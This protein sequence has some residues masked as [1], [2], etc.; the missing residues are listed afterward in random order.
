VLH[1]SGFK[2]SDYVAIIIG[3]VSQNYPGDGPPKL[4]V[5]EGC[6]V[7]MADVRGSAG[8]TVVVPVSVEGAEGVFSADMEVRFD[9]QLLTVVDVDTTAWTTGFMSAYHS[10]DGVIRIAMAGDKK[11]QGAGDIARIT[12]RVNPGLQEGLECPLEL[13]VSLNEGIVPVTISTGMFTSGRLVPET[14]ELAQ[15]YPNPFNPTTTIAYAVPFEPGLKDAGTIRVTL[16]VYNV[17]GQ[18]VRTLVDESREPGYYTI[19]WNGHNDRGQEFASGIYF[20]R[21]TAGT[22][23]KTM[24]MVLL[25]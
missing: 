22:F 8:E 14:F 6:Q 12:F 17:L 3:D 10:H 2:F 7:T 5:S 25:K 13:S 15:N 4:V 20:Y 19:Q 18:E 11:L 23:T 16:K 9:P 1:E 24:K 21:M